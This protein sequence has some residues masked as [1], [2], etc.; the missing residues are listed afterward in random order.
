MI[1]LGV[2]ISRI[3]LALSILR[4]KSSSQYRIIV[5]PLVNVM[6]RQFKY[7]DGIENQQLQKS[8]PIEINYS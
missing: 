4:F 2:A 1:V 7:Y 3:K 5:V 8:C 6:A